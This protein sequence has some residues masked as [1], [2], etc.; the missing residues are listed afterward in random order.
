MS[1]HPENFVQELFY[2]FRYEFGDELKSFSKWV[3]Y[4]L[5]LWIAAGAAI[6]GLFAYLDIGTNSTAVLGYAQSRSSYRDIA[7]SYERF[8]EKDGLHL[9]LA[10]VSH[11]GDSA[12]QLQ[13]DSA[14]LK[15]FKAFR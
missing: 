3:R 4:Y 10:D 5:V 13:R 15:L 9:D 11:I 2:Y 1:K 7:E 12:D 8:F 14:P 6:L